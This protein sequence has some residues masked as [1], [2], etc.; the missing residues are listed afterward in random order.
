MSI[1][2][3][4]PDTL[5]RQV[6]AA[7]QGR[8]TVLYTAKGQPCFMAVIP[9]FTLQSIDA[10]LGTGD[11]PAFIVSGVAKSEIFIGQYIGFSSNGEMISVPGVDP[12]RSINFDNSVN[13]ARANGT[14]WHIMTNAEWAA[15]A[16]WCWKNGTQPRGNDAYGRSTDVTTERAVDAATGRLAAATGTATTTTRT[17][18][19]PASWRHDQTPFGIAD[20]AGNVFE[21][22]A[23]MRINAG[24]IQVIEN[25]NAAL[26]ATD[27][28]SGSASW[29]AIDG[30][31][32]NLVAP[33]SAN[34]VKYATSGT[35]AYTLVRTSGSSFEGMSNPGTTP[36]ATAAL[37]KLRALGLYPVAGSGL[38]GDGFWVDVTSER[39]PFRG[40]LWDHGALSGVFAVYLSF[41]RSYVNSD[42]GARPAFVS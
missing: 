28:S 29:Q 42:V 13:L 23:G 30:S 25:N 31:N 18:S 12:I 15:L 1:T 9:K 39:V 5:R 20:L 2:I 10:S 22:A 16:L 3:S 40:G 41:A 24:E 19:G 4:V 35:T 32:G 21:W 26:N 6:E 8:N 17:G 36:V 11:H 14:G 33:G 34:T 37:E 27:L 7:S 38:G